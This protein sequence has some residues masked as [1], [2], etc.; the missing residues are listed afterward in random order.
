MIIGNG[1]S[2]FLKQFKNWILIYGL[3]I[4]SWVVI[5]LG[6]DKSALISSSNPF[7]LLEIDL[8]RNASDSSIFALIGMWFLMSLAMMLPT[9]VPAVKTFIDLSAITGNT[10]RDLQI[11]ILGYL[12]IWFFA[13][14]LGAILQFSLA[15]TGLLNDGN[16]SS[17]SL[18][19]AILLLSAGIYQFSSLKKACL[20]KCRMPLTFFME[21]WKTSSDN[22]LNLGFELGLICLGCCWAIMLLGFI[23]G[24]MNILW[25]GLA[26][27]L[28]LFEKIPAIGNLISSPLGYSFI[29]IGIIYLLNGILF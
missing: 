19:N 16:Q 11:L 12:I 10:H 21:R 2:F 13:S 8:C 25:M 6:S 26:T 22:I 17:S 23:G 3:I 1:S 29:V 27:L 14:I 18:L 20:S 4:T 7:Y 24:T 28:M 15:S 5:F 9:F